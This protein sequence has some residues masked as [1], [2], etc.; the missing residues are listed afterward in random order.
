[1]CE[2]SRTSA[3]SF[4]SS[5]CDPGYNVGSAHRRL[6]S[7]PGRDVYGGHL[8]SIRKPLMALSP[9][10]RGPIMVASGPHVFMG[11]LALRLFIAGLALPIRMQNTPELT[12]L[13]KMAISVQFPIST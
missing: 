6:Y 8:R 1:M 12:I 10:G 13:I 9:I 3:A 4:F 5:G 2:H 7:A 11:E